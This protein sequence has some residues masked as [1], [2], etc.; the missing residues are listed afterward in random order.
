MSEVAAVGEQLDIFGEKHPVDR[1]GRRIRQ[2]PRPGALRRLHRAQLILL[3]VEPATHDELWTKF[4]VHKADLGWPSSSQSGFRSRI[5]EL[6][7]AGLV[8]DSAKR[9]TTPSGR[10]S[11]VWRLTERGRAAVEMIDP[12]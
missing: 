4:N 12:R 10:P 3:Y 2:E 8:E 7:N 9:V 1:H 5:A 11:I 6:V